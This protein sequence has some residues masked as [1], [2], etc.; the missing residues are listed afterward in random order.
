MEGKKY[1][2][3]AHQ[4]QNIDGCIKIPVEYN[5]Q[6]V[7]N[8]Y[9]AIGVSLRG[10][11]LF[12]DQTSLVI[13]LKFVGKSRIDGYP[14]FIT[15]WIPSKISVGQL[16]VPKKTK[17]YR[18]SYLETGLMING[19]PI[20]IITER[21]TLISSIDDH[22]MGRKREEHINIKQIG[23]MFDTKEDC[24]IYYKNNNG[25]YRIDSIMELNLVRGRLINA[26]T[27]FEYKLDPE[28]E[29]EK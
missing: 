11:Y 8:D 3:I 28:F 27:V 19:G 7:E 10:T 22:L 13:G 24:M 9:Y 23:P 18:A 5:L 29:R 1:I 2:N 20:D 26:E 21:A 15:V 16:I 25:Y 17:I 6:F 12:S 4:G 14:I